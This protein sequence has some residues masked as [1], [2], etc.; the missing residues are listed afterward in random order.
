[1]SKPTPRAKTVVQL[2]AHRDGKMEAKIL[3]DS[4]AFQLPEGDGYGP[5]PTDQ[6]TYVNHYGLEVPGCIIFD[7]SRY[8][9][10]RV[11]TYDNLTD[12][13][14]ALVKGD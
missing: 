1:M 4:D 14:I 11:V 13:V 9:T 7:G 3:S 8:R 12:A 10:N 2:D 5:Y 6:I